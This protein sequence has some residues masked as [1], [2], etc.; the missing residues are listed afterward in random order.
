MGYTEGYLLQ[1][2]VS[3]DWQ[4][5]PRCTPNPYPEGWLNNRWHIPK[6]DTM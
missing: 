4:K 1:H 6:M 2:S 3:K 5:M